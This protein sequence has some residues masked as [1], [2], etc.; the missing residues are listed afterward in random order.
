L[1]SSRPKPSQKVSGTPPELLLVLED[2]EELEELLE[3]DELP[4]LEPL[5]ELL[6][7]LELDD[8]LLLV[9]EEELVLELELLEELLL[10]LD[11]LLE[12]ELPPSELV[13]WEP[14][15][16]DPPWLE[17]PEL[18]L[19]EPPPPPPPPPPAQ[20]QAPN[21]PP[22]W[23]TCAPTSPL[24]QVQELLA[25]T[26]QPELV[27][28]F[29]QVASPREAAKTKAERIVDRFMGCPSSA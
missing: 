22:T 14:P 8:E 5:L 12:L 1:P 28:A 11:E 24:T 23:H 25:P 26:V 19:L 6:D 18:P 29:E 16:L 7:E 20:K 13:L 21:V 10:E 2:D 15:L 17:L 3:L 4:L 9:L 27:G